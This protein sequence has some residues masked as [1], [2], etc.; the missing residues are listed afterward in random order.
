[1]T[2][3]AEKPQWQREKRKMEREIAALKEIIERSN[4]TQKSLN[5]LS[6]VLMQEKTTQEKYMN[7]LLENCPDIIILLNEESCFVNCTQ[8]FLSS[9]GISNFGLI[10]MKPI[11]DVFRQ[12]VSVQ[13]GDDMLA[14]YAAEIEKQHSVTFERAMDFGFRGKDRHYEI[15]FTPMLDEDGRLEGALGLFHDITELSAAKKQ[16]ERA[17]AA[18]SDFLATVSHEIRTPM[19]AIMGLTEMLLK[20]DVDV[21]QKNYLNNIQVS[22]R[23]LLKLI[24]D[25]L[26]FAKIEASHQEVIRDYFSLE[27]TLADIQSMFTDMF[28]AKDILFECEFDGELPPS[29]FGDEKLVRQILTNVLNNAFKYTKEG[30]VRLSV[31]QETPGEFVFEV[32]DTG[33]GIKAEDLPRLFLAFEQ[34][35]RVKNK[36]I[37]G[38]GLGLAITKRLC[39]L[40]DGSIEVESEYQA[41]T[42]FIVR[43]PME[44]GHALGICAPVVYAFKAPEAKVLVVDDI[45]LNTMITSA[46]LEAFDIKADEADSGMRAIEMAKEKYYDVIFMDHMMPKMDGVE[47]TSHIRRIDSYYENAP[48]VALT[49]NA[50]PDSVK[51]FLSGGMTDYL[52][53]PL[54]EQMLAKCLLKH[55]PPE[56]IIG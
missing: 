17:N 25:I 23:T 29:V 30:S 19:N 8:A 45:E 16:A 36:G 21:K 9:A 7:L 6:D 4:Q 26:D 48:I 51:M 50:G 28:L 35:D 11:Q 1:M 56:K 47:A 54:E 2:N 32:K 44:P 33:I 39:E 24:N 42:T 22:S 49:A 27:N 41:G 12:Y 5:R 52:S 18:K 15:T 10:S 20:T 43:I 31:R 3:E 55:L 14:T 53:K 46:M 38:T 34:L 13:E 37:V 40:L